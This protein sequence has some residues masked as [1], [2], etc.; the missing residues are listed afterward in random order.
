MKPRSLAFLIAVIALV[1]YLLWST[2]GAR[3]AECRVCAEFQGQRNCATATAATEKEARRS[4]QS[5]AC[6]VIARGMD[7][8][9][10]CSNAPPVSAEC[11]TPR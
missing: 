3:R 7:E 10:A 1:G 9:I 4:A 5:T 2:M 11:R 6:G 8:S